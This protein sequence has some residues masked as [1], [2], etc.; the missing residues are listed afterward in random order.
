MTYQFCFV[1]CI[2][3]GRLVRFLP[4]NLFLLFWVQKGMQ[5]KEGKVYIPPKGTLFVVSEFYSL[6]FLLLNHATAG[7]LF[8]YITTFVCMTMYDL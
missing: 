1:Q 6:T 2:Y 5:K 7:N 4:E 3:L 8:G